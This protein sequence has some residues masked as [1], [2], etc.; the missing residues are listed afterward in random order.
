M[1]EDS[2]EEH[3]EEATGEGLLA[4]TSGANP[5]HP[6]LFFSIHKEVDGV[7]AWEILSP[8][9]GFM[10]DDISKQWLSKMENSEA[11]ALLKPLVDAESH[12]EGTRRV[13]EHYWLARLQYRQSQMQIGRHPSVKSGIGGKSRTRT[14]AMTGPRRWVC[15]SRSAPREWSPDKPLACILC[16]TK[17]P[18]NLGHQQ[19]L[20]IL[21][22]DDA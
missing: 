4:A 3:S 1:D 19:Q 20:E 17:E 12:L 6:P 9:P 5:S 13:V 8:C 18:P 7:Q 10:V 11:T 15:S 21:L 16:K 2:S 14:V 22:D